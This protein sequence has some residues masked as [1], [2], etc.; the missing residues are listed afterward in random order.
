MMK[1]MDYYLDH[2]DEYEKLTESEKAGLFTGAASIESSEPEGDPPTDPPADPPKEKSSEEEPE[3]KPEEPEAATK[4]PE[5][6]PEKP[7][8]KQEIDGILAKDGKHVI[9]YK[10]LEEVQA[11]AQRLEQTVQE[12]TALLQELQAAAQ[13]DKDAGTGTDEQQAV[14]D[15]YEGDYPDVMEDLRPHLEKMIASKAMEAVRSLSEEVQRLKA[16][17][18]P[19][20]ERQALDAHFAAIAEK[21]PNF[22]SIGASTEFEAWVQSK[23][24]FL[25]KQIVQVAGKGTAE[26]VIEVL[27][28]FHDEKPKDP[29]KE[30]PKK[31]Q[32]DI[33][34]AAQE[35]LEA[36]K[37]PTPK[38]LS[39]VPGT[40]MA[41]HDENE[42]LLNMSAQQLNAKFSQMTPDKIF[43]TLDRTL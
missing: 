17:V 28:L 31:E 29:P 42:A 9:P 32:I 16:E 34:K 33:E 41:H 1:D 26:E 4:E 39:D 36:A 11:K 10:R 12:Q 22:E 43:E 5:P 14:L 23:P 25:R 13:R 27:D 20:K 21:Y 19:V 15:A 24:E 6:E 3:K 30:D 37:R 8:E 7:E 2:S 35:K 38:S 18:V 40:T